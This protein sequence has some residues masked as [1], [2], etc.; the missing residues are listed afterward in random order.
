MYCTDIM[1]LSDQPHSFTAN[2]LWCVWL[3]KYLC[4]AA[5]V[6]VLENERQI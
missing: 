6:V 5:E 2:T 4:L 1:P 3:M